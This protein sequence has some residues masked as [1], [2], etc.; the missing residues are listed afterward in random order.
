M[1]C[2]A[3]QKLK[4]HSNCKYFLSATGGVLAPQFR[5]GDKLRR[6]RAACPLNGNAVLKGVKSRSNENTW[7]G[8]LPRA[9]AMVDVVVVVVLTLITL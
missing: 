3:V 5:F 7:P 1:Y 8:L 9:E 6:I 2:T 4:C